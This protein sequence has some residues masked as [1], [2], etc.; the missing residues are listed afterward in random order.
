MASFQN[1]TKRGPSSNGK[2]TTSELENV[3]LDDGTRVVTSPVTD[4][5]RPVCAGIDVHKSVLMAAICV[6]NKETLSAVFYVRQFTSANSDI[7]RMAEWFASYG[8]VDVCMESTGKYWIPVYDILEQNGLKPI[9]TH[10]KYV[11]Q[12]KGRKTGFRDAIHIA[13]LFR[14]DLVVASFI[15]PADIRDLRELCRYRLKLTYIRTSEKNRF[16]NSMTISKIRLDSV[17]TDPFGKS[18]QVYRH[19][20]CKAFVLSSEIQWHYTTLDHHGRDDGRIRLIRSWRD[21]C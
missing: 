21:R 7:R 3:T 1:T 4:I 18:A 10:P 11:K 15:P 12:A 16:Q 13:N 2:Y 17:F 5:K 8:V 14:M 6:T 20:R 9:L 19:D